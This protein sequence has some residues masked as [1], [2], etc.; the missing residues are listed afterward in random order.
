M[1]GFSRSCLRVVTRARVLPLNSIVLYL[2]FCILYFA[3]LYWNALVISLLKSTYLLI[4][5]FL[6]VCS[7]DGDSNYEECWRIF[8]VKNKIKLFAL[9]RCSLLS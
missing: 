1:G 6:F 9:L 5:L 4:L 3:L 2:Y 7:R 8:F